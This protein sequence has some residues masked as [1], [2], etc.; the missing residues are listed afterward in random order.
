M[1][2][3]GVMPR[4]CGWL[5]EWSWPGIDSEAGILAP[6]MSLD[7]KGSQCSSDD[8]EGRSGVKGHGDAAREGRRSCL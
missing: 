2:L 1:D 5:A 3:A 4:C 8:D 7:H 6:L